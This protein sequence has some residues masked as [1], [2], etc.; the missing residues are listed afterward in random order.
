MNTTVNRRKFVAGGAAALALG[1]VAGT[2]IALADE[3]KGG[4]AAPSEESALGV[5]AD[6][7]PVGT[8]TCD[9]C[10]VGAG[11]SGLAAAV[12]AAQAGASVVALEAISTTGGGGRG[13][14]GVFGVGS[15]MQEEAGIH[16]D[17]VEVI[18]R[19]LEYSHNRADGLKW[20]D[21]VNASGPNIDWLTEECGVLMP[22]VDAY[23][24]ST[25]FATFHWFEGGR[26]MNSYAPQMTAKAE[27]NGAKFVYNTRARK[28][29]CD[30][31]GAV[32]GVIA[33]RKNPDGSDGDYI[34][35]NCK[36]VI[37]CTGGFANN[38]DYIAEGRECDVEQ[39]IRPFVGFDGDALTMALEVGGSSNVARFSALEML[40]LSGL[41]GGEVGAYGSG[42]GMVVA[43][44]S[45]DNIWVGATGERYCAENSGDGNFLSL[46]IPALNQQYTYSIFTKKQ[47]E[48]NMHAMAF[49]V[50]DFDTDMAELEDRF[51]ENPYG[52]AFTADTI[53]ELAE[54]VSAAIPA[55][56]ADTLVATVEHYNEMCEAGAD[57]DFGKPAQYL[58]AMDEGPFY[59]I[60]Q[61]ISVCVTFGGVRTSRKMEC[62]K[63][64]WT[65]IPGL[66][67][68]GVD[69]ADLWPNVYTMNVPGGC[70]GNNVNSGRVAARSAVEYIGDLTGTID[71]DG[72]VADVVL[73]W[74]PGELPATMADGAY[75]SEAQRGMFG[76]VVATVTVEN[77]QIASIEQSNYAETSY[78][79]VP[80]MET[81]I[82]EVVAAQSL[83]VDTV[84]G[85][86]AS[87]HAILLAILAACEQASE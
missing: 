56:K 65:V 7:Q 53:E 60:Q 35:V 40:T 67:C 12:T 2:G 55:I 86:T 27:E 25:E 20:L 16:I 87:C 68:A 69:S 75:T 22:T 13:T 3:A 38:N 51:A 50:R 18:A 46:Q 58:H 17:P 43:S 71:T 79:G 33:Q 6:V 30:E 70:N 85:A 21:M 78:V 28:L 41:P 10:V 9:V 34:Q 61:R 1:A 52:D 42:N 45:G 62:I 32:V 59:F 11:I 24:D 57:T 8:Y 84:A 4:Q 48:D 14:E 63:G 26:G 44:H 80:A 64:D 15:K 66:Y 36:A 39:V 83:D 49:P 74:T 5:P 37:M 31:D 29:I 82:E 72:D 81:I 54:K 73:Q 19:E 23:H 47:A 77:G 76:D